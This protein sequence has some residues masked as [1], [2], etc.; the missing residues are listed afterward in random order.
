MDIEAIVLEYKPTG[1]RVIC[2][3]PVMTTDEDY[4]VLAKGDADYILEFMESAGYKKDGGENYDSAKELDEGGFASFK[5]GNLNYIIMTSRDTYFKYSLATDLATELN[6]Q[7]KDDR[8]KV[9]QWFLH[10]ANFC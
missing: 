1:S 2:N 8:I 9:F 6:L 7:N 10:K 4:A 5:K 3:P